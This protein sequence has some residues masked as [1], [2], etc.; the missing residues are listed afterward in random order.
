MSDMQ[1]GKYIPPVRNYADND[2]YDIGDQISFRDEKKIMNGK[3]TGKTMRGKRG[4]KYYPA[5]C[6]EFTKLIYVAECNIL[7]KESK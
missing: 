1:I 6:A 5:S 3:I 4:Y 7:Y 2:K